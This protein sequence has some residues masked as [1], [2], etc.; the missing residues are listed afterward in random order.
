MQIYTPPVRNPPLI[1]TPHCICKYPS[2]D[3]HS[4]RVHVSMV[5]RPPYYFRGNVFPVLL[6]P[7][8]FFQQ[9]K[10]SSPTAPLQNDPSTP[11]SAKHHS[12]RASYGTLMCVF[13]S[14]N[15]G[16][17]ARRCFIIPQHPLHVQYI[18]VTAVGTADC[19]TDTCVAR[20]APPGVTILNLAQRQ[21]I[22]GGAHDFS[23]LVDQC[24]KGYA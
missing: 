19:I 17:S 4:P 2:P 6:P 15:K 16:R 7:A 22:D 5:A 24:M 3:P 8:S 13:F 23:S 18:A 1:C 11:L 10:S 9:K 12:A 14:S 21:A 20:P